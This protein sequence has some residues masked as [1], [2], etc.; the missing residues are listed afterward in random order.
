MLVALGPLL[1]VEIPAMI[2]I[3]RPQPNPLAADLLPVARGARFVLYRVRD[4]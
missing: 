1:V 2:D 3:G 4:R